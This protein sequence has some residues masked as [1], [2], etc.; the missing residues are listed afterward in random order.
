[1]RNFSEFKLAIRRRET[2]FHS[3]LYDI[4]KKF[5]GISV[6]VIPGLHK[7]LY[8][9]WALRTAMWHDFW[10]VVYYEPMFKSMCKEVGP[11]FKMYYGGNG[12]TRIAGNLNIYIGSNVTMFDNV[13]LAGLKIFDDPE[14][15]IGDNTYISPRTR[16]M[17]AKS[18]VIGSWSLVGCRIV[19]DNSG[20][21]IA[22]AA[23]R[24]TSGAGSPTRESVRPVSVGDLC[25]LGAG[26]CL[27]PGARLGDGV[28]A[29][30]GA[31][32]AGEIP[33]F[34]LVAGNP[35]RIVGKL[36]IAEELK[37][38]FGEDRYRMWKEQQAA[39]VIDG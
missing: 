17:V 9:E 32:V 3:K 21:P 38:H 27:Y 29:K 11:G 24:M 35:G 2:P 36:P 18:V 4:A 33:P 30:V 10:R 8:H 31:H 22:N 19:M 14:L 1:M 16:F 13:S 7:F 6:P 26:S 25:L 23:G 37:E 20:H 34:C 15:R 5:F 28:V 39:V 12:I